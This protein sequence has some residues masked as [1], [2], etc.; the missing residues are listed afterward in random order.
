MK[1][2]IEQFPSG[3]D[4]LSLSERELDSVL[5]KIVTT[6]ADGNGLTSPRY[7]SSGELENVYSVGL[8]LPFAQ[9]SQINENLMASCQRLLSG[10]FFMPA[11]GQPTGVVTVTPL[12]REGLPPGPGLENKP[13]LDW[14]GGMRATLAVVFTDIVGSTA[15]GLELGDAAMGELQRKHFARSAEL[16]VEKAGRQIKTIGDSVMAVFRSVGAA[17]DYAL[18]LQRDPGTSK[19]QVRVGIHTGPVDV[20]GKTLP[21]KT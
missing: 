19:L 20:A 11:P 1:E 21:A 6:R 12:G 3:N 17:F 7:L 4:I 13:L 18:A 5:L 10:N 16:L 8:S 9:L 14:T 2:L 15:L